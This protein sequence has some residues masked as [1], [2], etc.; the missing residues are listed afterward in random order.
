MSKCTYF[1]ELY[2]L[3][4][5]K[6]KVNTPSCIDSEGDLASE[7]DRV[8]GRNDGSDG[9]EDGED[10]E[11]DAET[12]GVTDDVITRRLQAGLDHLHRES[13]EENNE[14]GPS[15]FGDNLGDQVANTRKHSASSTNTNRNNK[16]QYTKKGPSLGESI[17]RM[18]EMQME[19]EERKMENRM[20]LE[21]E[22]NELLHAQISAKVKESEQRNQ[23][24]MQESRECT[25]LLEIE[26]QK[27]KQQNNNSNNN[28]NS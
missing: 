22:W 1:D 23:L 5:D 17:L 15:I 2:P 16:R 4:H 20:K 26:L 8:L 3:I 18:G 10:G 25:L 11:E 6:P 21:K 14:D 9:G 12:T 28:N 27:L 19:M 13:D 24:L 7:A